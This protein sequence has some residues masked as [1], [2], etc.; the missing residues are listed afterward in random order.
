MFQIWES[1]LF[2]GKW[3]LGGWE[4]SHKIVPTLSGNSDRSARIREGAEVSGE[5]K[6]DL[7]CAGCICPHRAVG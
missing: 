3:V 1:I 4:V 2:Q 5:G 6:C 7:E